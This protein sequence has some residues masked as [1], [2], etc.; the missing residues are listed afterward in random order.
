M[1]T[2]TKLK[3]IQFKSHNYLAAFFLSLFSSPVLKK[4]NKG[5]QKS[6][7]KEI[8]IHIKKLRNS[9]LRVFF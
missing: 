7:I 5:A 9:F 4:G 2:Y 8:F 3:L 1:S 6:E